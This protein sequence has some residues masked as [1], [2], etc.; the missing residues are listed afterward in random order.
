MS[1][2]RIIEASLAGFHEKYGFLPGDLPDAEKIL[3]DCPKCTP[4][5]N[6]AGDGK[7][8]TGIFTKD[9]K[10]VYPE[11]PDS[12]EALFWRHL[13]AAGYAPERETCFGFFAVTDGGSIPEK[14]KFG[15]EAV[16][17]TALILISSEVK[18]GKAAINAAGKQAVAANHVQ[19]IDARKFDDRRP[20]AGWI[21]AYGAPECVTAKASPYFPPEGQ[22]RYNYPDTHNTVRNPP[23][24]C[25]LIF[26]IAPDVEDKDKA[27]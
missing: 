7:I 9:L 25:G 5:A 4:P 17:G 3:P 15:A 26:L 8:G 11:P 24:D 14:A 20:D 18:N 21:Q 12:E 22:L 2:V 6:T 1:Q 16:K 13:E 10:Y 27:Q 19:L 23:K